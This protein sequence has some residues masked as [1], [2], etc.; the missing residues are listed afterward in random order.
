[1]SGPYA[2]RYTAFD[3]DL[4]PSASNL[5]ESVELP[6]ELSPGRRLIVEQMYGRARNAWSQ[7][8]ASGDA[9]HPSV[10]LDFLKRVFALLPPGLPEVGA[11]VSHAGS[12]CLDWD[13]DPCN[14]L[15]LIIKGD[16]DV[17]YAAYFDGEQVHGSVKFAGSLGTV[18]DRVVER[19]VV[20][21]MRFCGVN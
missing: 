4:P 9:V 7:V 15:S 18:I 2:L 5:L 12:V 8:V 10:T 21:D 16:G 17:G 14:T 6:V 19:W 11:Y 3:Y 20:R 13:D 1:M